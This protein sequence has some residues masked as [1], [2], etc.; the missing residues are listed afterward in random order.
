[1]V[2]Y[3]ENI[4]LYK[5]MNLVIVLLILLI[6]CLQNTSKFA[7]NSLL[8]TQGFLYTLIDVHLFGLKSLQMALQSILAQN[9][10]QCP[11]SEALGE[12]GGCKEPYEQ[13]MR[14]YCRFEEKTIYFSSISYA[15]QYT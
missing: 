2:A 15:Y 7:V 8:F 12:E 6:G 5:N 13:K 3:S 4:I 11:L 10:I 14:G 9:K 1:M